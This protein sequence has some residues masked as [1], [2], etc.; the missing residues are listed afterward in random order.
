MKLTAKER[1]V[2]PEMIHDHE[3]YI[4]R[5]RDKLNAMERQL[6]KWTLLNKLFGIDEEK[7][8][9]LTELNTEILI[10]Q[11]DIEIQQE[12]LDKLQS[13]LTTASNS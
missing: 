11:N 13:I 6:A 5:R 3:E 9:E 7:K 1:E 12:R 4:E 8:K 10:V 2:L